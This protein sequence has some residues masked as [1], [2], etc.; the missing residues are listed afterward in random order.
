MSV[1]SSSQKND[2]RERP[3]SETFWPLKPAFDPGR[4]GRAALTAALVMSLLML[5]AVSVTFMWRA[6]QAADRQRFESLEVKLQ[7]EILQQVNVYRYGLMGTRSVFAASTFVDRNEFRHIIEGRELP[8][9][10]P[11]ATGI[12]YIDRVA[13]DQ[14]DEFLEITRADGMPDFRVKALTEQPAHDNHYV[15]KYIEPIEQNGAA[16]GLDIGSESRRRAAAERAMHGGDVALTA[17]ITL[18]Q[19]TGNGPG[20]L[21]LL[22]FYKPSMPTETPEQREAAL[23]GWVYMTI[24]AERVFDGIEALIDNELDFRV[25]DSEELS[26]DL[27]L[28]VGGH[29]ED[30]ETDLLFQE[31]RFHDLIP[32]EIG[33]RKWMVAIGTASEFQAASSLGVWM[34]GIGGVL[35]S[36]LLGTMLQVQESSLHKAQAIAQSMTADLR[37]AAL[38][39]RLT[40][41]PN[42]TAI[43]DKI[44]DAIHRAR[45]L[46]NYHYAVLFL[47][48]D[49]FKIINDSMGH[50]AGDL[51]LQEIG[52]RLRTTL[53]PNDSA[54]LGSERNTA[55][56][57]G[58]D[59]FIVLLDG[60]ARPG[61]AVVVAERL[62]EV[63]AERY[64]INGRSINSTAS[65]GVVLGDAQYATADE[66][67]RD[68]DAAMYE[69]KA[70]GRGVHKI[71]DQTMGDRVNDRLNIQNEMAQSLEQNEF[72]LHY[73]P[74]LVLEQGSISSFEALVRWEHPERGII[75]PDRFIPVAE[76]TGFIVQLGQ[77]VLETALEQYAKW[78]DE[79]VLA[80]DCRINVNLSRK[81]LVLPGL[82][83][84]VTRALRDRGV[85]PGCLHLEVTES[86][87]MQDPTAAIENLQKLR[88]IGV[89]IDIDDFG[90]GH[91]SLACLH[92]FPVDV[93]KIDRAFV[94]NVTQAPALKTVLRTVAELASNL[95]VKVVAEGIETQEQYE[96]LVSLGCDYGQ[97]YLLS[98]PLPAAAVPAFCAANAETV[99]RVA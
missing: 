76:D 43:I 86:Q 83:D 58:G 40:N 16:V 90:T 82:F 41:L 28:Y 36:V 46:E 11:A 75:G 95:G 12:G 88:R 9:E 42:R 70:D 22:P 14:I 17:Q 15:I 27:M 19:A 72:T 51:L 18:V 44:Q 60:L 84:D 99:R 5:T 23:V 89:Q 52:V 29:T 1:Y 3:R 57:L 78:R 85:E 81:Q 8:T 48:F 74:I 71:F 2:G 61:D 56:R 98:K 45:R 66:M 4:G 96:L 97:G 35:L 13:A 64:V 21:I 26:P 59:E 55:A 32:V 80:A 77:W 7:G 91:S 10:F 30:L 31:H 65:I 93:L 39:D 53:R 54:G 34:A 69:A 73:Q 49:R 68:A 37:R 20:F 47:D 62:L 63:L 50:S 67:I 24:L 6:N 79:G 92:E 25:F 33:G 38:T 94:A 87:I